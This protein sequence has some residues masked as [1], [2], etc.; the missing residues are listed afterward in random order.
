MTIPFPKSIRVQLFLMVLLVAVPA[1]GI[2]LYSGVQSRDMALNVAQ[3][4]TQQLAAII[5]T[6]QQNLVAGAEQMMTALA[7]LP[8]IKGH[9]PAL[10]EP[11]LRKLLTLNPMYSNIFLADRSGTVWATAVPTKPPF[12]V[13]D[14]RYFRNAVDSGRLA[15]GEYVISRATARPVFNLGYPLK[16]DHGAVTGVIGVGFRID[17]YRQLLALMHAPPGTSYVLTDHH[18]IILSRAI[19]PEKYIGKP[20]TPDIFRQMQQSPDASV[21][22]RAGISGERRIITLRKLTLPGE[23]APYLYITLGIPVNVALHEANQAL[24]REM[25]LFM[26][27]LGVAFG[28]AWLLGKRSITD[29]IAVLEQAA[30]RLAGGDHL[31]KVADL[32]VGGELGRLALSFDAM[33][34]QLAVSDRLRCEKEVQL[35][36]Q[37]R[38]LEEEVAERQKTQEQLRAKEQF[39]Q[40]IIETEPECVK[41][42][43]RDGHL[44]MMNRAGLKMIEAESFDAVAGQDVC[45]LVAEEHRGAFKKLLIDAY[46]GIPGAL[47]FAVVGLR[48]TPLWL[49]SLVVP[50]RD[51]TGVISA[52]L[53]ITRN[54]TKSKQS[55]ELLAKN[56]ARLRVIFETSQAGIMMVA[57]DGAITFANRR[58]A[59]MFGCTLEELTGSA[60]IDHIHPDEQQAGEDRMRQL[61]SGE[62]EHVYC[63]RHYWRHDGTDFWGYLSGRRLETPDDQNQG[64]IFIIADITERKQAM[65]ELQQAKAAAEVANETKSRF[66]ANMSHELRTPMNGVLGMIQLAQYGSLDEAQQRYLT[67]A[68]N[69]GWSLVRILNDILDLTKIVERKLTLRLEPL[70]LRECVAETVGLLTPEA[71][72]KG[73]Q[74]LTEVADDVPELVRGDLVRLRQVLTNLI[75]NAIKF[76]AQGTV[77]IRVAPHPT[78]LVISVTD[79]GIGIPADKQEFV[80]EPFSQIDDSDTRRFGGVGLGLAICKEIVEL[81]GGTITLESTE[82]EGSHISF[83]L[84]LNNALQPSPMPTRRDVLRDSADFD[85]AITQGASPRIL[86]VED[87]PTNRLLL[88]LALRREQYETETAGNGLQAVEKW[89]NVACD[90]IIMDVQMPVMNGIEAT[91]IIREKEGNQGGHIPIL[92]MT[93]HAFD[94]DQARCLATGMDAYLSK[95]VDL[96]VALAMVKKFVGNG[97]RHE[98]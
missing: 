1:V 19:D 86:I 66:L 81:M 4:D 25:V 85:P 90:L 92:A 49:D 96:S 61:C 6:E 42:V 83:T 64:I 30:Q 20:Y 87:D 97:V 13:A 35:Q 58:M 7:Q 88:Q 18:G 80:F 43:D 75:G 37:N 91:R 40:T 22:V 14:R 24:L 56:E 62:T 59:E 10:V 55:E 23:Q 36:E 50:Y 17:Q 8:E 65:V 38:Q 84:P 63:E 11:I 52:A 79:T 16:D 32:V 70:Q 12:V 47:Q 68:Y 27:F 76:T 74:V 57:P 2:M 33:V 21:T 78:G 93:A 60:Y 95:P 28:L 71:V 51:D 67:L 45:L 98:M 34:Q 94:D 41:M 69:A 82:G 89:E 77:L 29:R 48:G 3:R 5:A 15:A 73:L 39:L 54:I 46:D 31:G 26:T 72:H 53:S 44:L 9:D